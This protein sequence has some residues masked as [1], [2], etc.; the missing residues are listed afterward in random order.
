MNKQTNLGGQPNSGESRHTAS[1]ETQSENLITWGLFHQINIHSAIMSGWIYLNVWPGPITHFNAI[2]TVCV[3]VIYCVF[4]QNIRKIPSCISLGHAWSSEAR[5]LL[6][7][8]KRAQSGKKAPRNKL[9]CINQEWMSALKRNCKWSA[10]V[11]RVGH[12][13]FFLSFFLFCQ[14]WTDVDLAGGKTL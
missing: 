1:S 13:A 7:L 2:H 3:W 14:V 9:K 5:Q 4:Y 8:D 10:G 11:T 12:S 6:L